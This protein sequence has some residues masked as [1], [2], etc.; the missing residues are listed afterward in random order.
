[1]NRKINKR[2]KNYGKTQIRCVD[3][4]TEETMKK[5]RSECNEEEKGVISCSGVKG[6]ERKDQ[7]IK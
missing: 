7:S 5:S 6:G 4:R 1:M 2:N 3:E